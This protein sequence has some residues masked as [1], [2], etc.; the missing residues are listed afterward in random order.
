MRLWRRLEHPQQHFIPPPVGFLI[1]SVICHGAL[2]EISPF[3]APKLKVNRAKRHTAELEEAVATYLAREPFKVVVFPGDQGP[4]S[5]VIK[6]RVAEEVPKTFSTIIGDAIHNL[7]T[8]LDLMMCD[9][10]RLNGRSAKGVYFPFAERPEHLDMMIREK[11]A[12]RAS[13]EVVELIRSMKPYRQGNRA[14][15]AIHDLDIVDK[16]QALI[17]IAHLTEL[18]DEYSTFLDITLMGATTDQPILDG[19]VITR[20]P[21]LLGH[22]IGDELPVRW[23]LDLPPGPMGGNP[24]IP[25]LHKFAEL[26]GCGRLP[27]LVSTGVTAPSS[28]STRSILAMMPSA[29]DAS[30]TDRATKSGR[31]CASAGGGSLPPPASTRTCARR[32]SSVS[33]ESAHSPS[34][35]SRKARRGQ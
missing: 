22:A 20:M 7:R 13:P 35:H 10:V 19:A 21:F 11:K 14:L 2:M 25:T 29:S 34:T 28:P 26:V 12:D 18:P 24:V 1:V 32:P 30:V 8:A 17:P 5:V 15:R 23:N 27:F 16:H 33:P 4:R 3:E 6:F 31:S 9:L